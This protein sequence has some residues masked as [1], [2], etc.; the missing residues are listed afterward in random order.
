VLRRFRFVLFTILCLGVS[1]VADVGRQLY[2]Q[3]S[4]MAQVAQELSGA[5]PSVHADFAA[6]VLEAL[7]EAY[8]DELAQASTATGPDAG[9][10]QRLARWRRAMELELARL[11]RFRIALADTGEAVVS[12]DRQGQVLLMVEGS[13][14]LV[15]WPRVAGQAEREAD[16][17]RRFCTLHTC[18][19]ADE[20]GAPRRVA[21][22]EVRGAW[23][24]TQMEGPGWESEGGVRCVFPDFQEREAREARCRGLAA[25]L[26]TLAQV[27][28]RV[29]RD[30]ARIEWRALVVSDEPGGG[31]QRVVVN[32][33]GDYLLLPL[34][35]LSAKAVDWYAVRRWLERRVAGVHAV[36][37]VL[38][39]DS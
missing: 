4:V 8:D 34:D 32:G 17:V 25:D 39:V 26:E 1:A 30:G 18:P 11:A 7:A 37:T 2:V 27:L 31:M 9:R 38:T 6:V 33:N 35:A 3:P 12:V 28:G 14:L 29:R 13:P 19:Q 20:A 10:A 36:E 23:S 15:S 5:A 21:R 22:V 16:L 24:V